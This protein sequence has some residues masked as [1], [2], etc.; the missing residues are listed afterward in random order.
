M[1]GSIRTYFVGRSRTTSAPPINKFNPATPYDPAIQS[2]DHTM[3]TTINPNYMHR[4]LNLICALIF[5][6][7][8]GLAVAAAS[9]AKIDR[10]ARAA[11]ERLYRVAPETRAVLARE[12]GILVFPAIYKAGIGVG[13]EVG[14][15][16]LLRAGKNIGFYRLVSGSIGFQLRA[17]AGA[18]DCVYDA[19]C[20]AAFSGQRGL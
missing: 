16:A 5:L 19:G 7:S 14:K 9:A 13:A 18:G 15:G 4:L 17:K 12:Q 11:L 3:T 6:T 20:D 10:D 1:P 8:S 2:Q